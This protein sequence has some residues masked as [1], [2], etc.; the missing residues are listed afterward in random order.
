[1]A[2]LVL[3]EVIPQLI[4]ISRDYASRAS[5]PLQIR[6]A[7]FAELLD[8]AGEMAMHGLRRRQAQDIVAFLTDYSRKETGPDAETAGKFAL[9]LSTQ[10]SQASKNKVDASK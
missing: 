3:K 8:A 4:R 6:A 5:G 2:A 7:E 9:L 10:L 1:M